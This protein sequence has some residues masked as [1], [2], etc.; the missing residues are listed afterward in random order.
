LTSPVFVIVNAGKPAD[1]DIA[2]AGR[3]A[4]RRD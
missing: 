3:A 1:Y 4:V 2:I